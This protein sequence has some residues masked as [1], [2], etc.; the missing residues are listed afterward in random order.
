MVRTQLPPANGHQ[1]KSRR[2]VTA[3]IDSN[4]LPLCQSRPIIITIQLH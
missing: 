3:V 2:A 4:A 1:S